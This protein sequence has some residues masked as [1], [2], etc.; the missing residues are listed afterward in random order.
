MSTPYFDDAARDLFADILTE[1]IQEYQE[2]KAARTPD[3]EPAPE[4]P[5][6][7]P[8]PP[9]ETPPDVPR[10]PRPRTPAE[11]L[12]RAMYVLDMHKGRPHANKPE[13]RRRWLMEGL[14][15]IVL[16]LAELPEEEEDMT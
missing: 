1:S 13:F 8:V 10:V 4:T 9:Q 16:L 5:E 2:E 7:P 15:A 3:P 12:H 14:N 11:R 6:E